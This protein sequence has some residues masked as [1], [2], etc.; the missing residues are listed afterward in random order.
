MVTFDELLHKSSDAI[1]TRWLEA[2]LSTYPEE[3][4]AVFRREKDPFA[5]P[6]GHSLRT[7]TREIFSALLD[8]GDDAKIRQQLHE[9]INIRAVQELSASQALGF[10]FEL[11]DAIREELG[12]AAHDPQYAPGLAGLDGQIDQ[13]AL[14]AFDVF[15]QSRE[16]L[17][18]LR[19][20]EIKRQVSWVVGKLNADGTDPGSAHS[21]HSVTTPD[22]AD[23]QREGV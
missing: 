6:I 5:N 12:A 1:V 10:I 4:A 3:S 13:I 21:D 23:V 17:S 20:N 22:E 7:G 2:A 11:R 19:V 14:V 18:E 15:V 8:G 16:R 9:I